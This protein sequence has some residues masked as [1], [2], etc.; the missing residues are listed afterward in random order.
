MQLLCVHVA[1]HKIFSV[2]FF[3]IHVLHWYLLSSNLSFPSVISKVHVSPIIFFPYTYAY[4]HH[5]KASTP[6]SDASHESKMHST[7]P[8][9]DIR[10][11]S[12]SENRRLIIG[13][14]R[15]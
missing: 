15:Y 3:P 7:P 12:G 4:K 14:G 10:K 2:I 6:N 13:V 8:L 1:L 11:N 5:E 9:S